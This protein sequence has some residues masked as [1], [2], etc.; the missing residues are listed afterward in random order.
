MST[1]QAKKLAHEYTIEFIRINPAYLSDV[2][3]NIP[4]MVDMIADVNR[5]FYD[6]IVSNQTLSN[7]Y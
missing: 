5:R 1:D 6:A 2:R 7:L 3:D 4:Q